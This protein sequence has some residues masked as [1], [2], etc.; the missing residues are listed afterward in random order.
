[1]GSDPTGMEDPDARD[2]NH[3]DDGGDAD[4]TAAN[5]DSGGGSLDSSDP[6]GPPAPGTMRLVT[7]PD[8]SMEVVMGAT[9]GP[10][11]APTPTVAPDPTPVAPSPQLTPQPNPP[12]GIQPPGYATISVSFKEIANVSFN[13]TLTRDGH[14]VVSGSVGGGISVTG[15]NASLTFGR[16][17]GLDNQ[18]PQAIDKFLA[19]PSGNITGGFGLGGAVVGNG[20]QTSTEV[21]VM[22]PQVSFG[23]GYGFDLGRIPGVGW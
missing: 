23:F 5:Q 7:L 4:G 15:G 6:E 9:I 18:D 11:S 8:G 14:V 10:P 17:S 2:P 22:S 1:M 20:Q 12:T 3:G 19:G 21:G 13:V 16:L